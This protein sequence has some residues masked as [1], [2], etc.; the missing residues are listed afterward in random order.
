[1]KYNG[2][3]GQTWPLTTGNN[4]NPTITQGATTAFYCNT[5]PD[6]APGG[7]ANYLPYVVLTFKGTIVQ[8]GTAGSAIPYDQLR[9]VLISSIDW[10][11]S[12][13][14]TVVSANHVQGTYLPIV[15]FVS[16]GY[17]FAT[18]QFEPIPAAAGTYNFELD[19][20]VPAAW[21][22]VGELADNTMNLALLFQTS[23]LK[24]NMAASSVL[25]GLSTAATLGSTTV[26]ASAQLI[27]APE[28]ILGTPIEWILEQTVAGATSPQVQIRGFGTDTL[29][30]GVEQKGGVA[31][32]GELT[33]LNGQPGVFTADNV[34]GYA[35]PWRN[36]N[37]TYHPQSIVAD[38]LT[39]LPD[40]RPQVFPAAV[41]GGDSEYTSYPY[42]GNT[43]NQSTTGSTATPS[44]K[45]LLA[46]IMVQ[47]G[48]RAQLTNLQTAD[49]DQSYFL[50]L[51]GSFS[52]GS[53]QILGAYARR[54][55]KDMR[56]SWL[57]QVS[58]GGSNSL[59]AHVLGPNWQSA[60]S[61]A[62]QSDLK[63][64]VP[65]TRH[66]TTADQMTYLPWQLA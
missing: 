31:W 12:W 66:V 63:Q 65:R 49:S 1:M 16:G 25:S 22:G 40:S 11:T 32:L 59:A 57:G 34:T 44:L 52:A 51:S 39:A 53:H 61:T 21:C 15:E 13:F 5:V 4:D 28:L 42:A 45:G 2:T 3:L 58:K 27:P 7:L 26:R 56:M 23:Q 9:Q 24:I 18:R 47:L 38:M 6:R 37:Q 41:S 43:S 33:S 62:F 36:Q 20:A 17:R 48:N 10:I 50:N 35:F 8:A 30:T 54:F 60:V 14:G 46:W 64:R 29:M 19:V 55:T